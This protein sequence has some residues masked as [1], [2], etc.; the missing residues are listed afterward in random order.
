[1]KLTPQLTPY[2]STVG[3]GLQL[4]D[5]KGRVRFMVMICGVSD[6]ITKEE[7]SVIAAALA[8]GATDGIE[9]AERA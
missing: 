1:M 3:G 6:G 5:E 9:L 8:K 4:L 7:N 2:S